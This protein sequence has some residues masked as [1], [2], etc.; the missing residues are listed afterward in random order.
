MIGRLIAILFLSRD[1][2][3]RM[4]LASESYAQHKALGKFYEGI[5]DLADGLSEMYQGRHDLIK[6]IPLLED[7]DESVDPVEVL[8]RHLEWVEE[9]R[10]NAVDKSDTAIQNHIDEIVSLY[11]TTLYKLRFLK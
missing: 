4:H 1:L 5:I 10:Y 7:E 2:A 6:D 3:H 11:L 9:I 8:K